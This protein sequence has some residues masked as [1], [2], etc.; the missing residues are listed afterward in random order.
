MMIYHKIKIYKLHLL[1]F[2][3]FIFGLILIE[4]NLLLIHAIEIPLDSFGKSTRI[5]YVNMHKIFEAF[6]ETEKARVEL[7]RL[8]EERKSEITVKKEEI[9]QLKAEINYFQDKMAAVKPSSNT[10]TSIEKQTEN[11]SKTIDQNQKLETPA[12]LPPELLTALAIPEGSPLE[13]LFTPPKDSTGITKGIETSSGTTSNEPKKISVS[14]SAPQI[15]PGIPSP[16]PQ[17]DQRLAQLSQKETDLEAFIGAAEQEIKDLEEGKTMTLLA[18]IYNSL[19]EISD[20]EGYS[21]VLDKNNI[22]YG[23]NAIDITETIIWRLSGTR[24]K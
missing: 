18:R 15:L 5:A 10:A 13:F 1:C 4:K 7:N 12:P 16:A 24:N 20:K 14:T 19:Q 21:I 2:F 3:I 8:I 17:L 23:D 6:P 22:L 9:A 11:T